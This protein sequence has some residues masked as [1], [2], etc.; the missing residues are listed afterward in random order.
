MQARQRLLACLPV[1]DD[2][3]PMRVESS[4]RRM[5]SLLSTPDRAELLAQG[6]KQKGR[7][8]SLSQIPKEPT[9]VAAYYQ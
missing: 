5:P 3:L 2:I 6:L 4:N 7:T 8:M 1:P 9:A